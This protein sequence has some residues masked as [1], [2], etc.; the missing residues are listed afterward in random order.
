MADS[1]RTAA[2][3]AA[4]FG[5]V[6]LRV[7]VA[8]RDGRLRLGVFL[9]H[10]GVLVVAGLLRPGRS[11]VAMGARLAP[12]VALVIR[13][14]RAPAVT[15]LGAGVI[16]AQGRLDAAHGLIRT[17][18]EILH[19]GPR[20]YGLQRGRIDDALHHGDGARHV[21]RADAPGAA[22]LALRGRLVALRTGVGLAVAVLPV[23]AAGG[24]V[25]VAAVLDVA[26]VGRDGRTGVAPPHRPERVLPVGQLLV[27]GHPHQV[28]QVVPGQGRGRVLQRG[29]IGGVL[30][31]RVVTLA[32][33]GVRLVTDHVAVVVAGAVAVAQV[34]GEH[35]L[36]GDCVL[37]RTD[38][39]LDLGAVGGVH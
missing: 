5:P 35:R 27:R 18:A 31:H 14:Q 16:S 25:A 7:V 24:Q 12:V 3:D 29:E 33:N 4:G 38:Q 1:Q 26:V 9:V 17:G 22:E 21:T 34:A 2:L 37:T 20:R 39:A 28:H 30:P 19:G 13:E 8:Q 11:A 15:P 6:V 32:R 10:T 36:E 23:A